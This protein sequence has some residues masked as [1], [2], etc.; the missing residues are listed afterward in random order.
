MSTPGEKS[1]GR[2]SGY[3]NSLSAQSFSYHI[4]RKLSRLVRWGYGFVVLSLSALLVLINIQLHSSGHLFTPVE[5]TVT[6]EALQDHSILHQLFWL[7]EGIHNQEGVEAQNRYPEG[8]VFLHALYGLTWCNVAAQIERGELSDHAIAEASWAYRQIDSERGSKRFPD[9]LIP[10]HGIFYSGWKNY[11][12]GS[13]ISIQ[14]H[15]DASFIEEFT[16]QSEEIAAAFHGSQTP[17]LQSYAGQAWPADAVVAAASLALYNRHVTPRF[18][19][20]IGEW[21][22]KARNR[23]DPATGLIPHAV[24]PQS[25]DVREGARGSSQSLILCF[26]PLIDSTFAADQ[27]RRYRQE[28][29]M[30]ILGLPAIRE[31]RNGLGGEGDIDSGPVVLGIGPS[32]SIVG[33]GAMKSCGDVESARNLSR[34]IE[35][36]GFPVTWDDRKRYLLGAEPVADAFLVWARTLPTRMEKSNQIPSITINF[37]PISLLSLLIILLLFLPFYRKWLQQLW[38]EKRLKT[39]GNDC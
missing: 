17:F 15:P 10:T 4:S 30:S 24:S 32:A 29:P 38:W 11:L 39:S 37:W 5:A 33:I 25:G 31:Y 9:D 20:E 3:K 28:F 6:E 36:F 1:Y 21:T 34:V 35:A 13:I 27:F 7:Q 14:E 12:L 2:S 23:L 22:I 16:R 18:E 8:Y 19:T 26:L